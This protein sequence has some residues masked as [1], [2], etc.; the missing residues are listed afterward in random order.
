[1]A[2]ELRQLRAFVA[3]AEC[4]S[5]TAAAQ[6]L[7]V[8]QQAVSQQIKALEKTLGVTLFRRTSR[9]VELTPE[10][11]VFLADARRVLT[12]A[13]R[14]V[15][16]VQ[17]AARGEAGAVRLGYTLSTVYDTVPKVLATL[18]QALP[19][20]KIDAREVFGG[21]LVSLIDAE[22]CDI[23][24]APK[25]TYPRG[26]RQRPI[27]HE[28]FRVAVGVQH[29]LADRAEI[30][31]SELHDERFEFWPREMAPGYYD[32]VEEACHASGFEPD[33]DEQA[34]GSTVWGNIAHGR[35]VGLV[36]GSLIE[37]LPHGVRLVDLVPPPPRLTI[38]AVWAHRNDHPAIDRLLDITTRLA[39]EQGWI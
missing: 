35:G 32:A 5:F 14:A 16:R 38:T 9:R 12:N 30:Q 2:P 19:Q 34:A 6:E 20:L 26:I 24:L 28:P 36:V 4:S 21:D 33:R 11:A 8:A 10:G 27:R 1:M 7:H 31:L 15:S 23:A 17:A 3:V 29:P 37:Q 13:D 39:N 22:R 25:S 18:N